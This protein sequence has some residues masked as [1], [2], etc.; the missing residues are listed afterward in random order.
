MSTKPFGLAVKALVADDE[1][2]VLLI[3]RSLDSN[4]FK[5]KWDL[6]GGKV[7]PGE[8]FDTALVR[9]VYEE[10]GLTV[11][12]EGVAGATEYEMPKVRA[13]V[14]FLEARRTG[15]EVQL[16]SEHD[17][18]TWVPRQDI[19]NQDLSDQLQAFLSDYCRRRTR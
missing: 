2:R 6:P 18:F 14:L 17:A 16:S 15:G 10:T 19:A 9:E 3:R 5:H 13:V 1:N 4:S 11:S 12:I 7:D 8:S